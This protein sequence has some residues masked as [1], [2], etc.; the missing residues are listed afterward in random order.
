[1]AGRKPHAPDDKTRKMVKA[2]MGFGI[3]QSEIAKIVGVTDKTLRKHYREEIETGIATAN[4]KVAENLFR[5]ATGDSR[6][7]VS[8]AIFW[9][10]T[11]AR[12]AEARPEQEMSA[13][14][15]IVRAFKEIAD[16]LPG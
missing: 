12:W 15:D 13:G 11:R 3:Q 8:A 10:K 14:D 2:M 16:K 4:A 5:H 9:L 6:G 7:A 1:M